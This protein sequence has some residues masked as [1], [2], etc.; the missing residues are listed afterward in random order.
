MARRA[1]LTLLLF[2][3]PA[4]LYVAMCVLLFFVQRS[5]IYFPIQEAPAPGAAPVRF[6]TQGADLKLW[7]VERPGADALLY[8]GGNAEDVGASVER[9]AERL[10]ETSFY[11]VN[12]RGY[13]GSTGTPTERTLVADAI[14]IYDRIHERHSHISVV[15]RSLGSGVAV[16]L[17]SKRQVA[18]LVLVTP[19]DSLAKVAQVHYP[20]FPVG[21]LI[22]DRFDSADRAPE[23][24]AETLIIVA[25]EDEVIPRARTDA[26]IAAFHAP[27]VVV[28][29]GAT[30]NSVD[31][32]RQ[33]F[34]ELAMFLG[35]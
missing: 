30:H 25:E 23:I 19:F 12:Y 5:M 1:R 33:Y 18:R 3:V 31:L 15:G 34:D 21:M 6:K 7:T 13:G 35:R 32:D 22:R 9:F 10:P 14:A 4:G 2:L 16:Q 17:A 26:L 11:F 29:K 24:S 27:R 28:L 20:W 8:F